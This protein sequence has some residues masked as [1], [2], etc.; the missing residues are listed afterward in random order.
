MRSFA[1][2]SGTLTTVTV[3]GFDARTPGGLGLL[4]LVNPPTI[5]DFAGSEVFPAYATLDLQFVPEPGAAL[6][7]VSGGLFLVLVG[8]GRSMH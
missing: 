7:L 5:F 4:R 8:R 1:L 3:S 2:P 6:L